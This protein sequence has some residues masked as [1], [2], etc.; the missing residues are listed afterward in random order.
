MLTGS[1]ELHWLSNIPLANYNSNM[2][3]VSRLFVSVH[4]TTHQTD[5][6][7]WQWHA[8][9]KYSPALNK[10]CPLSIESWVST[11]HAQKQGRKINT[12][13]KKLD[14]ADFD[15]IK[16]WFSRAQGGSK[17]DNNQIYAHY[18]NIASEYITKITQSGLR[19]STSVD[20]LI[21]FCSFGRSV[22]RSHDTIRCWPWHLLSSSFSRSIPTV[23]VC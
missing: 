1:N 14:G 15:L 23:P 12:L 2:A 18:K 5:R 21:W 3:T 17:A 8:Q 4:R 7:L 22:G 13:L 20:L 11:A 10:G 19:W 6:T 9:S 16:P